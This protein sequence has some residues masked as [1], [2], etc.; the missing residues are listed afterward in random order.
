MERSKFEPVSRT[1]IITEAFLKKMQNPESDEFKYY[2]KMMENIP[3]LK[4]VQRTHK[5][6]K[7]YTTKEGQT[8]SCN[9]GKNLT[10]KNMENFIAGLPMSE[11][12]MKEYSFLR[13]Y[14]GSLQTSRHNLVK[15]WFLAQFPNFRTNPLLYIYQ[16]PKVVSAEQ[17]I[18]QVGADYVTP[19]LAATAGVV[20]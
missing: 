19:A 10:Y 3:G 9:P 20:Q 15:N 17:F 6:P 2:S 12:Y 7:S 14:A 11:Q 18:A 5:T 13:E 16:T 4:V 8:F 1:L